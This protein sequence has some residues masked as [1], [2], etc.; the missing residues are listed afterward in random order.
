MEVAASQFL[1]AVRGTRSQVAFA[2]RLGYRSNPITDWENGRRYPT[3]SEALRACA[4]AGIDVDAAFARFHGSTAQACLDVA[5]WLDQLRGSLRIRELA[6]RMGIS[7]HSVSRWLAGRAQP[8]VPEYFA[9][10]DAI[11]GRLPELVA[12]LVPIER[13]PALR[14]R[15]ARSIAIRTIAFDEPWTEAIVR[16]LETSAYRELGTHRAGFIAERL[17]ISLEAEQRALERMEQA[18]IVELQ[19]GQYQLV[20]DLVVDTRADLRSML[21]L[22]THWAGEALRRAGRPGDQ[23]VFA[24]AIVS[25]SDEDQQRIASRLREVYRE[26]RAIVSASE[27]TQRAA[28]ITLQMVDWTERAPDA[29]A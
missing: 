24:Y 16:L 28:L 27:P 3:A 17:G 6:D 20:S 11:T 5:Q 2:R 4:V 26:I 7:R 22:R 9:L 29:S 15:F 25:V 8:R 19:Q 12:Q 14:E 23:D 10:I 21:K 1:R 13:V 18:G